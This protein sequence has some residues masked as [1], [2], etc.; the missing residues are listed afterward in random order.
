MSDVS[1]AIELRSVSKTYVGD[2][3][4]IEALKAVNLKLM[5]GEHVAI[6]GPSGSGK[7]TLLSIL[8]CLDRPDSGSYEC[9]GLDVLKLSPVELAC[10]RNKS[11]GFVFQNLSLLPR[12]SVLENVAL[13]FEYSDKSRHEAIELARQAL[14]RVGMLER[15]AYLPRQLSGGQQQR[16]AV[17]RAIVNSPRLLLADEPTGALDKTSA[18]EV[19]SLLASLKSE[20]RTVVVVSHDPDIAE[21]ADR[22]LPF[23]DGRFIE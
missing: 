23:R 12:M 18:D 16:I 1:S 22:I 8:G 13:P 5:C 9:F 3:S 10:F 7:S 17:A 15:A 14:D 21:R 11:I 20:Q 19:I 2:V 6:M 4:P